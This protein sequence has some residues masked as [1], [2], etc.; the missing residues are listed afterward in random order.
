MTALGDSGFIFVS[1]FR[2]L[3]E[4]AEREIKAT[5]LKGLHDYSAVIQQ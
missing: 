5:T 4:S 1:A 2:R 3:A